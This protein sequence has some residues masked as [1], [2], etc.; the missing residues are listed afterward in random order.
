M[1][2]SLK[3]LNVAVFALAAMVA[4]FCVSGQAAVDVEPFGEMRG[5]NLGTIK[6]VVRDQAG[7]PIADATVAIFKLG[8]SKLLKQ[9]RSSNDGSFLTRIIPGKYTILAVAE[10][11]NPVTIAEVEVNRASLAS[12][13]FKLER[14]GSG[15]T[16]LPHAM[17]SM[18]ASITRRSFQS[19]TRPS[20]SLLLRSA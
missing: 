16:P 8:T 3:K 2:S 11:F 15:N 6:G 10:G 4:G 1:F 5:S 19:G 14:S 9:V 17:V 12:Y 18:Q 13:G 7:K 20:F